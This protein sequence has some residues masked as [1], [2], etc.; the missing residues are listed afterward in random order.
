LHRVRDALCPRQP[1]GRALQTRRA[2]L[3]QLASPICKRNVHGLL[4]V[5]AVGRS[6]IQPLFQ[7]PRKSGTPSLNRIV[8]SSTIGARPFPFPLACPG[9]WPEVT[10]R[11]SNPTLRPRTPYDCLNVIYDKQDVH[12]DLLS[13]AKL[14]SHTARSARR[15]SYFPSCFLVHEEPM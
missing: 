12:A 14:V 13:V 4:R 9:A 10:T 6:T 5:A 15:P 11:V 8:G 2:L 7:T 1:A 3:L